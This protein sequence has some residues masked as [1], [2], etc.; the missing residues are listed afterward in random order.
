[1]Q[2]GREIRAVKVDPERGPIM[3]WCFQRY[4]QGDINVRDL[5]EEQPSEDCVQPW[6]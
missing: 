1:M 4:A 6:P 2:N 5:L 3:A